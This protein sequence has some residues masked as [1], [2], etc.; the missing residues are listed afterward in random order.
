MFIDGFVFAT[1]AAAF[2]G[3]AKDALH[4]TPLW[5]SWISAS[6]LIGTF[7][8]GLLLGYVTDRVGRKP[9]FSIDLAVFLGCAVLMLVVQSPWQVFT[10]GVIMG[11]AVGADYS[12]GSPLLGEFVSAKSRG[13]YLGLLE[14][15]WNVGYV[16]AYLIG[17][18]I[19]TYQPGWWRI[20]LA[21]RR[22]DHRADR[23]DGGLVAGGPDRPP[24]DPDTADGRLSSSSWAACRWSAR[25]RRSSSRRRPT[26][27]RSPTRPPPASGPGR[28]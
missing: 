19:N 16:V 18:L 20:I 1:F 11:L 26:D 5:E 27:G 6:V 21:A 14:I 4:V 24:T 8:G 2:A 9:M 13:N 23:R 7:F 12:I 28:P 22:H 15:M 10:L 25:S 3:R 17:Y